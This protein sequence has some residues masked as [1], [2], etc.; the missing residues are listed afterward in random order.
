MSENRIERVMR[1]YNKGQSLRSIAAQYH[2]THVTV[3]RWLLDAGVKL[4][5]R[6]RPSLVEA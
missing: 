2:K 1:L 4:R 6:G 5:G 3:R